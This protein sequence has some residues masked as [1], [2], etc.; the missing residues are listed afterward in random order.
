VT[1]TFTA[2]RI[3][4][5]AVIA[6]L[7]DAGLTVGDAEAPSSPPPYV[8][9]YPILGGAIYGVMLKPHR[10]AEL[11]YQVTCVGLDRQQAE[12]LQDKARA[13]LLGGLTVTGYQADHVVP[14]LVGGVTREDEGATTLFVAREQYRIF[15]TPDTGG[16]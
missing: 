9:V 14:D 15:T 7:E 8:V 2:S 6:A 5:D 16:S 4:T 13:A 3:H 10:E 11:L 12:W 1:D